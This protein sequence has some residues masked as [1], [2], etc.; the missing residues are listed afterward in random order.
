[1]FELIIVTVVVIAAA[2]YVGKTLWKESKG[3]GC[4]GCNCTSQGKKLH[5][6]VR[7]KNIGPKKL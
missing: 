1:M 4:A 5:K 6:F 7:I 2:W 3:Q